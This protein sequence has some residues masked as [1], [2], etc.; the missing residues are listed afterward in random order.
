MGR[1]PPEAA[2]SHFTFSDVA[3]HL[4][5]GGEDAVAVVTQRQRIDA[6]SR[7]GTPQTPSRRNGTED[8][9]SAV[10]G[11]VRV[12]AKR[13][14][15]VLGDQDEDEGEAEP[16]DR[17]KE[18]QEDAAGRDV[19]T[20]DGGVDHRQQS[21]RSI[22]ARCGQFCQLGGKLVGDRCSAFSIGIPDPDDQQPGG[23]IRRRSDHFGQ[24]G[25]GDAQ[26]QPC[27]RRLQDRLARHQLGIGPRELSGRP[28]GIHIGVERSDQQAGAGLVLRRHLPRD[29]VPRESREECSDE[30]RPP[31]TS[32]DR[33][34]TT[35]LHDFSPRRLR[36]VR[37]H[38]DSAH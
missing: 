20:S 3:R 5:R 29:R 1:R 27:T 38:H 28:E 36:T 11:D 22:R 37:R 16:G 8:V 34:E 4:D 10:A 32:D 6:P 9:D 33:Q 26:L 18:C 14:T 19:R 15:E 13:F 12:G 21:V 31:P 24:R 25:R 23:A 7:T 17:G 2:C 30:Q 35:E